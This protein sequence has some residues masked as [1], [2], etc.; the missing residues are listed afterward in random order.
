MYA[1]FEVREMKIQEVCNLLNLTKKAIYYYEE[2]GLLNVHKD[3]N[4]YRIFNDHDIEQLH[5]ISLYRKLDIHMSDIKMLLKANKDEKN[6]LL[7]N[8]CVEKKKALKIQEKSIELLEQLVEQTK[9][10]KELD[11]QIDYQNISKAIQEQIPGIYGKMFMQHFYPYLQGTMT[12]VKQKQA[13]QRV[14]RFWDDVDFQLPWSIR[15]IYW[16][17]RHESE[18]KMMSAFQKSEN[19]KRELLE[20]EDAYEKAK[21]LMKY[22]YKNSHRLSY[23]IFQYPQRKLKIRLQNAGYNDI[24]LPALCELSPEYN[25]YSLKWRELNDK[26]C[27]DLGLYYNHKMQLCKK[28]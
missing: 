25:E 8:I 14:I 15:F 6:D 3:K 2:Q 12:T 4:G 10:W 16:L 11:E 19:M 28:E 18:E 5:E 26:V 21:E 24:F 9:S 20:S 13:Y 23:R 7:R 22:V 17:N 1:K 27:Q